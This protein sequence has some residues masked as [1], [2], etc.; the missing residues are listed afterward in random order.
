MN[1]IE[2][3]LS[4]RLSSSGTSKYA[5]C[6]IRRKTG[7]FCENFNDKRTLC[8]PLSGHEISIKHGIQKKADS[9]LHKLE[10]RKAENKKYS[11]IQKIRMISKKKYYE[12]WDVYYPEKNSNFTVK[13][14]NKNTIQKLGLSIQ[15]FLEASLHSSTIHSEHLLNFIACFSLYDEVYL[16][17]EAFDRFYKV[18]TCEFKQK[19]EILKSILLGFLE[20]ESF[21]LSIANI[22]IDSIVMMPNSNYKI[23]NFNYLYLE[24]ASEVYEREE[25][26]LDSMK[27]KILRMPDFPFKLTKK[28]NSWSF[29]FISLK[30]LADLDQLDEF[31]ELVKRQKFVKIEKKVNKELGQNLDLISFLRAVLSWDPEERI[32]LCRIC[33]H[34]IFFK[35]IVD[36]T[37]FRQFMGIDNKQVVD[38]YIWKINKREIMVL[39]ENMTNKI[40]DYDDEDAF[41]GAFIEQSVVIN[42]KIFGGRRNKNRRAQ[43]MLALPP[44]G[45]MTR[46]SLSREIKEK[47]IEK[48]IE[49]K[50]PKRR[51]RKQTRRMKT[52]MNLGPQRAMSSK[53]TLTDSVAIDESPRTAD[54]EG[55]NLEERKQKFLKKVNMRSSV[56]GYDSSS[57]VINRR[58]RKR[59]TRIR[60]VNRDV[61]KDS[62]GGLM[63]QIFGFL[64]CCDLIE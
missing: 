39:D 51:Q 9:F 1:T 24:T 26:Y 4:N 27:L 5:R 47:K 54:N 25:Q 46:S 11:K 58:K 44:T 14:Y 15:I 2:T 53:R 8:C 37:Y 42:Q 29:G 12:I 52:M 6:M 64:G 3:S 60:S 19:K 33:N 59:K 40:P 17:Y 55:S 34:P 49:V 35:I 23:F 32:N 20:I 43:T 38:D 61:N 36:S 7:F 48:I 56:R 16:M 13:I 62:M 28:S 57:S 22:D 31:Q 50:L 41:N 10:N 45:D 18:K 21:G 30:I 63:K